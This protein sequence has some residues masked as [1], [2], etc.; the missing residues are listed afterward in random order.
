MAAFGQKR[1]LNDVYQNSGIHSLTDLGLGF[2]RSFG[3]VRIADMID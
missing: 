1:P 2:V 3:T